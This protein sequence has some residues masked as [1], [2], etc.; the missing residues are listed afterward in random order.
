MNRIVA[1]ALVIAIVALA[2]C[3][4]PETSTAPQP[5]APATDAPSTDET[6]DIVQE[7][8]S[9]I[10]SLTDDLDISELDTL[11]EDLAALG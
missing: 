2:G 7:D 5:D 8:L 10:D 6:A 11:D 9:D 1:L 3:A 4:R